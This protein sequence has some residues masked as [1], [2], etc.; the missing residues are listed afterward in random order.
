[1]GRNHGES[2]LISECGSRTDTCYAQVIGAKSED[3]GEVS[4]AVIESKDKVA[5]P[6][7]TVRKP[8]L[9]VL[10]AGLV[11]EKIYDLKDLG[12]EEYPKTSTGKIRKVEL[13]AII[14]KYEDVSGSSRTRAYSWL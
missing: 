1:M 5:A 6:L 2:V 13:Q 10:G 4:I 11:P 3:A 14:Q 12:L 9:E 8:I 7:G